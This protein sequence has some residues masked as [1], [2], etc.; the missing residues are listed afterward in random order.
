MIDL[1]AHILPAIDDGAKDW[2]ET[3]DMCAIA[4]NDG[5]HTIV[6]T[7]HVKRGMY[8]PTK[9]LILSKV[10]ELNHLLLTPAPRSLTSP[11]SFPP[12]PG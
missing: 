5:I 2:Q 1:H 11:A 9:E 8:T 12:L 10:A 4:L 3:L 6:A 7:P